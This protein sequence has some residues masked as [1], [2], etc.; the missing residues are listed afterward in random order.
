MAVSG[1]GAV[2]IGGKVKTNDGAAG[3]SPGPAIPGEASY[4]AAVT[5]RE[6]TTRFVF[7]KEVN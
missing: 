3:S 5:E 7:L 1:G 6:V 2:A 4:F